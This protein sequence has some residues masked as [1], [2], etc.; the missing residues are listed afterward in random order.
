MF[1]AED[2]QKEA[3]GRSLLSH[4]KPARRAPSLL[5]TAVDEPEDDPVA[6]YHLA[7]SRRVAAPN[8]LLSALA[9]DETH[10]P[11][12]QVGA[13]ETSTDA[14]QPAGW[15]LRDILANGLKRLRQ[16][17]PAQAASA[18]A[19]HEP[20]D[21]LPRDE[22]PLS[23]RPATV[24]REK[25][26]PAGEPS[27]KGR[28]AA[29]AA[30]IYW[31]PLIDPMK[32]I[33]G[34]VNSKALIALAT[35]VGALIGVAIALS[36]PKMYESFAELLVDPRDL[37]LA[38]RTLTPD[39]LPSDATLA[40]VENQVRVIMSSSVLNN[41][42]D[43]LN[44]ANDPEFN[45][46]GSDGFSLRGLIADLRSLLSREDAA[47]GDDRRRVLA[48]GNLAERLTVERGGKTFVIAIGVRTK[49]ADK[50]ALIANTMTEAFLQAYGKIQS[51]TA[52]RAADELISK[53]DELRIGVE[54]AERKIAAFKAEHDIIDAQGKLITDEEILRL[55]DQ[56]SA[57]KARTLELN[58]RAASSKSLDV[59]AALGGALPE[60]LT[61]ATL[62]E[63]RTQYATLK[64]EVD[65]LDV[66]LG[67][68]HP[69]RM[70]AAAQLEGARAQ[71]A[72]ELRRIVEAIQVDLRR[73]VQLE[74]ELSARLAQLK[75]RQGG[76]NDELVTLRELERESTAKRAVYE[77]YL[78][79]ARET[80]EQR[81]M[82]AA[83]I[84]V[85]S[86]AYPP[87]DPL[88][89]SRAAIAMAG[90]VFGFMAGIGLGAARGAWQSLREGGKGRRRGR[91]T[92]QR[93]AFAA[94]Q[95]RGGPD[96][97]PDRAGPAPSPDLP[98]GPA[99]PPAG[100]GLL[101][102]VRAAPE[103]L[104]Q[105]AVRE[106]RQPAPRERAPETRVAEAQ[107]YEPPV[108]QPQP[109]QQQ[110]VYTQPAQQ[111]VYQQPTQPHPAYAQPVYAP[112]PYAQ[113]MPQPYFQPAFV[114]PQQAM[115]YPY[116]PYPQAPAAAYPYQPPMPVAPQAYAPA[117]PAPNIA[118]PPR[119]ASVPAT[120]M[121]EIR[122]ELREFRE[123]VRELSDRS[124]RRFY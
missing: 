122:D 28:R 114:Q 84:S 86:E 6:R 26:A 89:P 91:T 120:P 96:R 111:P 80:T 85:I 117:H 107:R 108:A 19:P 48:I 34:V 35:V 104:R 44:L 14:G 17:E 66:Q 32:V 119:F 70:A 38:D 90:T 36:T 75:V 123:A 74:Q 12:E 58:A 31:R 22:T 77:A 4:G 57:A 29:D 81:D 112:P 62:T 9:R 64:Q 16:D 63:L 25:S 10:Q 73:A 30:D 115:V 82:N 72:G 99:S 92:P 109:V 55:N 78:L 18:Y 124:R 46:E 56:L 113:P 43:Q 94:T 53:L 65:R 106:D 24:V 60:E 98:D 116:A 69:Q 8:P 2:R 27:D 103:R 41:V 49:S 79:R 40:I 93:A 118:E 121:E 5:S 88:G 23:P 37:Q 3:R 45:G 20:A 15:R 105:A 67:P 50:S 83:N 87:L 76:L 21:H 68:R 102:R 42:V 95:N 39:V 7:R 54:A 47:S 97:G 13:A 33:M 59:G 61:S 71:V 101:E 100:P 51:D 11:S 1:D 110:P 52:G